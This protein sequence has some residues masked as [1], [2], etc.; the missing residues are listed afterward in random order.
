MRA[1]TRTHA[2]AST[3]AHARAH[4][5][6]GFLSGKP[7]G[8]VVFSLVSVRLGV[9]SLPRGMRRTDVFTI[10]V[11]GNVGKLARAFQ[12]RHARTHNTHGQ[13][14]TLTHTHTYTHCVHACMHALMD[15]ALYTLHTGEV[16]WVF[17]ACVH[18]DCPCLHHVMGCLC[19]TQVQSATPCRSSWWKTVF[20]A[21]W[22]PSPSWP[23]S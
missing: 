4:T 23:Y 1:Q 15:S 12:H 16:V 10:G 21:V 6:C 9:C 18:L 17:E 7:L 14:Q 11:L 5:F 8:I 2:H 19:V 3:V 13:T 22:P 20:R